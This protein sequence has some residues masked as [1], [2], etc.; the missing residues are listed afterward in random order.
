PPRDHCRVTSVLSLRIRSGAQAV[1]ISP[2]VR[3]AHRRCAP[4]SLL[5]CG[6]IIIIAAVVRAVIGAGVGLAFGGLGAGG[7][8]EPALEVAVDDDLPDR[9]ALERDGEPVIG[10]GDAL[11]LGAVDALQGAADLPGRERRRRLDV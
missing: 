11:G 4:V 3:P 10:A 2:S 7:Q 5:A 6:S 9:A 8:A 1:R